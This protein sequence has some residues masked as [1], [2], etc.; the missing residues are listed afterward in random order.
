[1]KKILIIV[2]LFTLLLHTEAKLQTTQSF[3]LAKVDFDA[4]E[5]LAAEVKKHRSSR[6][7]NA[8][9]FV[10]MAKEQHTV[11]LDTR[12]DSMYALKHVKG[13]I[14]LNFSDFTQKNLLA[15][16]PN[17][18]TRILIYCNNNFDGDE[19]HFS[20]KTGKPVLIKKRFK[21]ITLALNIPTYI[22]LYGYGYRNVYELNELI[23]STDKRIEYEGTSIKNETLSL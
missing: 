22:N 19:V 7:I 17:P 6:L 11:I 13:A 4:F 15:L 2:T 18:N 3:P 9:N 20:E 8:N 10:A 5:T 23:Y 1:M 12:S 16:I 21:P 14:H